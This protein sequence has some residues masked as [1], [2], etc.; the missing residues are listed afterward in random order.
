MT[1]ARAAL[2]R[3]AEEQQVERWRYRRF[4]ELGFSEGDAQWL[5][6]H[7][8]DWH[9]AERLI[10]RGCDHATVKRILEP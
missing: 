9:A 5:I 10:L 1:E 2:R 6:L 3:V 4:R 7:G 8:V